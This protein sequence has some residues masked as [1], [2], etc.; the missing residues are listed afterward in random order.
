MLIAENEA[1][2]KRSDLFKNSQFLVIL[3]EK[4]MEGA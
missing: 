3:N 2:F 4:I 1:L